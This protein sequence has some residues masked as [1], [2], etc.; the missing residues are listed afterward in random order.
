LGDAPLVLP[1]VA[2]KDYVS[3][4]P[5]FSLN[6]RKDRQEAKARLE[7]FRQLAAAPETAPVL[8]SLEV[9]VYTYGWNDFGQDTRRICPRL[10]QKWSKSVCDD[11]WAALQQALPKNRFDLIDLRSLRES[12][13]T[14]ARSCLHPDEQNRALNLQLGKASLLCEAKVYGSGRTRFYTAAVKIDGNLG[15]IWI[16]WEDD[17]SEETANEM[18]DR[19]GKAIA[20]FVVKGLGS[21]E[22]FPALHET[23]CALR[24]PHSRDAPSGPD[25]GKA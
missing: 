4:G 8:P 13:Q 17:Q 10:R 24:R 21:I 23:V 22:D 7:A 12:D 20:A 19:E 9:T 14:Y 2:L 6:G 5:S 15:A 3:Q 16:V 25:C 11:P 1:F 18:A